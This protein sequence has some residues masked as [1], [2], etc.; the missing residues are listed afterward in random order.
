MRIRG[1]YRSFAGGLDRLVPTKPCA[2][3]TTKPRTPGCDDHKLRIYS[4]E[5]GECIAMLEGHKGALRDCEHLGARRVLSASDDG[6]LRVWDTQ[7]TASHISQ[8]RCPRDFKHTMQKV[9][10]A[11]DGCACIAALLSLLRSLRPSVAGLDC[12]RTETLFTY[13]KFSDLK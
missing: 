6:Q 10:G 7:R 12:S 4:M 9:Q 11:L 1:S 8:M 13:R 5:T 2:V 3:L